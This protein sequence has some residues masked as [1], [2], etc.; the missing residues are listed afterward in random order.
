LVRGIVISG[1]LIIVLLDLYALTATELN[2]G[3][4]APVLLLSLSMHWI[5][6]LF[7][8]SFTALEYEIQSKKNP[9]YGEGVSATW[10]SDCIQVAFEVLA[11]WQYNCIQV[12]YGVLA[13]WQSDCT[14]G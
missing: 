10:Q 2:F 13:T 14:S 12:D 1:L 3:Y 11:T 8:Y 7:V 6:L 5:H 4:N 9:G